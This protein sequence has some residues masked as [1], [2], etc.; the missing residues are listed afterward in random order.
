MTGPKLAPIRWTTLLAALVLGAALGWLGVTVLNALGH[1]QPSPAWLVAAGLA[2]GGGA[3]AAGAWF[4]HQRF[5]VLHR[6]P[7]PARGL[8]LT[9]LAKACA[10]AGALLA[11]VYLALALTNLPR[12]A[13]AAAHQ[14][15]VRGLVT[16]AAAI[17]LSVGGKLLERE[18][19]TR[20]P[21]S[22]PPEDE[23]DPAQHQ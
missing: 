5:H 14:R 7:D 3:A 19:Q 16:A 10:L 21:G 15:V 20:H 9:A 23:S 17:V 6:Y 2:F 13:V 11:G 12:W 1:R 4:A 22:E 8:A 18:C